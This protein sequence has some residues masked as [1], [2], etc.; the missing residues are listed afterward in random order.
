MKKILKE[1]IYKQIRIYLFML[2][3]GI[4]LISLTSALNTTATASLN[5]THAVSIG[6]ESGWSITPLTTVYLT[7]V[8]T[9][10]SL[11]DASR[12]LVKNSTALLGNVSLVGG[13]ATFSSIPLLAGVPYNITL[14]KDGASWTVADSSTATGGIV[15]MPRN[16]SYINVTGVIENDGKFYTGIN[17]AWYGVY[18]INYTLATGSASITLNNPANGSTLSTVGANFTAFLNISQP[19]VALYEWKNATVNVYDSNNTL[20]NS[21]FTTLSGNDTSLNIFIDSFSIGNYY[22]NVNG[23]Y[24]N[25]SYTTTAIS[26]NNSFTVG[27]TISAQNYS[28]YTYETARETFTVNVTLLEGSQLSL[29]K[30]VYNGTVYSVSDVTTTILS[31]ETNIML[32]KSIDIPLNAN[33]YSSVINDFY[34]QFTYNGGQVQNLTTQQQNVTFINLQ[35]CN[36]TYTTKTLNFTI[37]DELT[38]NQLNSTLTPITLQSSFK[39]WIGEGTTYRNYSYQLINSTSTNNFQYCILPNNTYYID[40]DMQYSALNYSDRTW[41]FRNYSISNSLRQVPLY[42]LLSNEATKFQVNVKQG[43][44][45]FI[46]ALV[47]VYKYF[48]GEGIYK[49]VMVGFTDDKGQFVGNLDLDQNYK[50]FPSKSNENYTEQIKQASCSA[51]PCQIDINIGDVAVSSFADFYDYFAQNVDYNLTYNKSLSMVNLT[52]V[53]KLGTANYWRLFVY[54]SNYT[55]DSVVTICD[56]K[57]YSVSG[58]ISCN[59][60]NYTGDITAKV[61]ISRSPEKLVEFITFVNENVSSILGTSGILASIIIILVI[62]FSGVRNPTVALVLLPFSLILLKF[63]GFLPLDWT[64]ILGIAIFDIWIITR[65]KT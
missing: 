45:V 39:Y 40:M 20:F 36:G 55:S 10:S 53:D 46:G 38:G 54:Q 5:G 6:L 59:Y 3:V 32:V 43:T 64:S 41:A 49:K 30:L 7:S 37:I 4:F 28:N 14:I 57:S 16:D 26:N 25:S 48:T 63:I 29:A 8:T 47:D 15:T 60:S 31:N 33:N 24:G 56:E 65:L 51:T 22:W 17:R 12:V 27:A 42:I 34:W 11:G 50:F 52:F 35:L 1:M 9:N 21:T 19:N 2:I 18:Q 58:S 61:Y 62:V 23:T 13:I 44:E